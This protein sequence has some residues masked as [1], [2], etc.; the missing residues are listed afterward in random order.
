MSNLLSVIKSVINHFDSGENVSAG[1]VLGH[2]WVGPVGEDL[3]D[4]EHLVGEH[5]VDGVVLD[6]PVVRTDQH[7]IRSDNKSEW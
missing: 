5:D 4:T 2:E 7:L 3:H 1:D 6:E